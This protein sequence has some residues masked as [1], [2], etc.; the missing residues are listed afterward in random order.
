M[1][2]WMVNDVWQFFETMLYYL[3]KNK[4]V[5]GMLVLDFW[6]ILYLIVDKQAG[7]VIEN[8]HWI[9]NENE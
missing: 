9:R 7:E 4:R 6:L 1:K 3:Y 8:I 2:F 5:H